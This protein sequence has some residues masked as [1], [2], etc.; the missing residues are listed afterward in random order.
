MVEE[1]LKEK[2]K[3]AL[4]WS[5]V[6]TISTQVLN[7]FF[8]IFLAR[9][10]FP[11]DYGVVGML[12]IF[13][14]I[15]S[16][17][18]ESG[19]GNALIN[20]KDATH[21]DFNAVFWFNVLFSLFL[22]GVLFFLTPAIARFYHVPELVWLGRISFLS[23]IF[24]A[25]GNVH[26]VILMKNLKTK[27]IAVMSLITTFF[28]GCLGI[29]LALNGFAFWGLVIQSVL[30]IVMRTLLLMMFSKWK[31]SLNL[32]FAPLKQF[33]RY[34][35]KLTSMGLYNTIN[36]NL[37][38]VYLGKFYSK[39]VVGYYNQANKWNYMAYSVLQGMLNSV[40]QPLFVAGSDTDDD[41][42]VERIFRKMLR[43]SSFISIPAMFCL[44]M[45]APE[46]IHVTVTEKWNESIP[47]LRI[48]AIGGAFIPIAAIYQS[49]VLSL[50][51]SGIVMVVSSLQIT[52]QLASVIFLYPYGIEAMLYAVAGI[53]VIWILVW[54]IVLKVFAGVKLR[55]LV[56]DVFPS[57][58]LSLIA[59][60]PTV[61]L[62]KV[63]HQEW[64]SLMVKIL[65]FVVVYLLFASICHL[66]MMQEL[67]EMVKKKIR[68]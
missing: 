48:V 65:L 15:S 57:L 41:H 30:G 28:S 23:L 51:R 68:K 56:Y 40:A 14:A 27:Q 21:R 60:L 8:G 64:L 62:G 67:V 50:K 4:F 53:N 45:V 44:A 13:T 34:G 37:I 29:I 43:F 17:L 38:T 20:K 9:I 10:L 66:D 58:I 26:L 35:L 32:D 11:E 47:L 25:L 59:V 12:S 42:R 3:K 55:Y 6:S 33:W 54:H 7:F 2:A 18:Q 49:F 16:V 5:G 31:P 61:L 39:D 19:F 46:F 36:N 63:I 52:L 22:Y 24:S 1:S